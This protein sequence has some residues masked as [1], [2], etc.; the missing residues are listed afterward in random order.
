[1]KTKTIQQIISFKASPREVYELLMDSKKHQALSGEKAMISTKIPAKN[2]S[3]M[4][5][6]GLVAGSLFDCRF[7]YP[8]SEGRFSVAIHANWRTAEQVQWTLPGMD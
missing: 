2:R 4:A 8:E 1:M 6:H 5:R 3:G 7:R